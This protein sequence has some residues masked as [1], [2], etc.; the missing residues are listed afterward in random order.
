MQTELETET[1][2][3]IVA[4]NLNVVGAIYYSHQL[5][6]MGVFRV[7]ERIVELYAQGL[8]PLRP[9]RAADTLDRYA[10]RGERMTAQERAS[11]YSRALGAPG[12]S[13]VAGKPNRDFLSLWMRFMVAVSMFVRQQG[14]ANL[15]QPATPAN[16]NVRNA[17]RALAANASAH[18]GGT[19][20]HAGRVFSEEV[21]QLVELLS[22]S[23]LLQAFGARDMWQVIDQVNRN[24]LGGARNVARYRAQAEAGSRVLQWLAAHA[25]QLSSAAQTEPEDPADDADLAQA[26][27]QWLAATGVADESV[28]QYSQPVESPT[29]TSPPIDMPAIAQDLLT[30]I[31][32]ATAGGE[33]TQA[34]QGLVALF[35]GAAGSGKT[36][37]AHVLADALG[38]D[39]LRIDL[40][41]VVSKYIGETEKNLDAIFAEAE[42]TGAILFFDEADALFGR[43][44]DVKDSDDRYANVDI[45]Y[46]LQRLEA[47]QGIVILAT[48]LHDDIDETHFG[49]D[50]RRRHRRRVSFPRK[51]S[52]G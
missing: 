12:G 14:V 36:L 46:L 47:H 31:G 33:T 13:A 40:A 10:R 29:M 30:A 9:G 6:Q 44:T 15:L 19:V 7:V 37:A 23:E 49:D 11:F 27:E 8:L 21:R 41:Q 25:A 52:D 32:L 43:R 18:G 51:R 4:D 38:H 50:W 45:A 17:A 34:L 1:D 3:S 28:Q 20:R 16:A 39:I 35:Q 2:L 26:V 42:R 24:E 48:N 22:E 5:E